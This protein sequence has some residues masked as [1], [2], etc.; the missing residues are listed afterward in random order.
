[1]I[2]TNGQYQK[3]FNFSTFRYEKA[4]TE[5]A[6][7]KK[8]L[9]K[10]QDSVKAE[11]ERS[12][13][14]SRQVEEITSKLDDVTSKLNDVSKQLST[15]VESEKLLKKEMVDERKTAA[16]LKRD[17]D[18]LNRSLQQ[19]KESYEDI[20]RRLERDVVILN[21][22]LEK[23]IKVETDLAKDLKVTILI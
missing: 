1:M 17:C 22:K 8:M 20:Q 11:Q 5:E 15:S 10:A 18:H 9:T 2:L 7:M 3:N 12:A 16:L 14:L 21:E 6:K 4:K 13:S 23:T 19:E